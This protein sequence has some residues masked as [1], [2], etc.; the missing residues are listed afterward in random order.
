MIF[1]PKARSRSTP[2][3]KGKGTGA[4]EV[5]QV[6][7]DAGPHLHKALDVCEK[8]LSLAD[9]LPLALRGELLAAWV[10][11]KQLMLQPIPSKTLGVE[12]QASLPVL[13][14]RKCQGLSHCDFLFLLHRWTIPTL[15]TAELLWP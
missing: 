3:K 1:S 12:A 8:V 9:R 5:L 7:P 13:L 10:Q 15:A 2:R 4:E 11:C 14:I 6:S